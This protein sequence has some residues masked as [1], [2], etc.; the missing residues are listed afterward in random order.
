M[1]LYG[2]RPTRLL[3][4]QDSLGKNTGVVASG[5]WYLIHLGREKLLLSIPGAFLF[6]WLNWTVIKGNKTQEEWGGQVRGI[7]RVRNHLEHSP[8]PDDQEAKPWVPPGLLPSWTGGAERKKV[9]HCELNSWR[10]I[11]KRDCHHLNCEQ[12]QY[13]EKI[14]GLVFFPIKVEQLVTLNVY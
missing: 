9:N 8:G 5:N 1:Q 11:C 6:Q 14:F 10:R 4:P 7:R 12:W 3:C 13:F 2:Q